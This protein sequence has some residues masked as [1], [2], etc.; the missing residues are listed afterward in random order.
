MLNI[1]SNIFGERVQEPVGTYERVQLSWRKGGWSG[2][3]NHSRGLGLSVKLCSLIATKQDLRMK[4]HGSTLCGHWAVAI[5]RHGPWW[6]GCFWT[7]SIPHSWPDV[8]LLHSASRLVNGQAVTR[9]LDQSC[10][11]AVLVVVSVFECTWESFVVPGFYLRG[12][13]FCWENSMIC[14]LPL[15]KYE[16]LSGSF[17]YVKKIFFLL[18]NVIAVFL[19]WNVCM[20]RVVFFFFNNCSLSFADISY[21]GFEKN[22]PLLWSMQ[23]KHFILNLVESAFSS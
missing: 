8:F 1:W 9:H 15:M 3:K 5:L 13:N 19:Q 4:R 2:E 7:S 6:P 10:A 21:D 12:K 17:W 18:K 22:D 14:N 16:D 20:I 23:I 11:A